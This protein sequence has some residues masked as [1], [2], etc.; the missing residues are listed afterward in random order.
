MRYAVDT[1]RDDPGL[2]RDRLHAIA[3]EGG[4]IVSV[5]W[6]PARQVRLED[7]T[8]SQNSGYVIVSEHN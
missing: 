2:L 3:E 8:H 5:I 4:H 1:V 6:Q 7:D